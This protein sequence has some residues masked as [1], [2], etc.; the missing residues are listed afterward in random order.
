MIVKHTERKVSAPDLQYGEL[1]KWPKNS[2]TRKNCATFTQIFVCGLI[3][4]MASNSEH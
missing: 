2:V 3:Q 1:K 4:V